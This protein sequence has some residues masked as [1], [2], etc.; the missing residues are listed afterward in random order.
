[1]PQCCCQLPAVSLL[2]NSSARLKVQVLYLW[3]RSTLTK[4]GSI[5]EREASRKRCDFILDGE[6]LKQD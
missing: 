4:S 6:A 2:R 1:M 3:V 5:L